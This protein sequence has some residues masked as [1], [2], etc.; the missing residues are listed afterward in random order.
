ME[1]QSS[2]VTQRNHEVIVDH[3]SRNANIE[4][5]IGAMLGLECFPTNSGLSISGAVKEQLRHIQF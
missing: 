3:G 5:L 1:V 4:G 2:M